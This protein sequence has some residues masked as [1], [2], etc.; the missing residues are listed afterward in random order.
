M[1]EVKESKKYFGGVKAVDG[2]SITV[3]RGGI[4][5]LI[6][7]NGAG[8]TTLFNVVTG[9]LPGDHGAV[10]FEGRNITNL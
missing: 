5:G 4:V 2:V 1:L 10:L 8:K 3:G 7:P 9:F 6:G